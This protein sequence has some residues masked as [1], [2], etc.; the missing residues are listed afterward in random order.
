MSVNGLFPRRCLQAEITPKGNVVLVQVLVSESCYKCVIGTA[1]SI[2]PQKQHFTV[3]PSGAW[4]RPDSCL[5]RALATGKKIAV[6]SQRYIQRAFMAE[7]A[8]I[9]LTLPIKHIAAS[10][11]RASL[12]FKVANEGRHVA[13]WEHSLVIASDC[14]T[15]HFDSLASDESSARLLRKVFFHDTFPLGIPTKPAFCCTPGRRQQRAHSA[16]LYIRVDS[17]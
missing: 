15:E 8:D 14:E 6:R 10:N 11:E 5:F 13:Q 3:R 2:P 9:C 7:K 1:S 4:R 17:A 16:L 12:S